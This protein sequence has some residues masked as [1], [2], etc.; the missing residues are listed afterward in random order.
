[1]HP[2]ADDIVSIP[3]PQGAPDVALRIHERSD[4]KADRNRPALF[5]VHGGGMVIG[6]AE[7]DD[8]TL[9]DYLSAG[10]IVAIAVDYRLAPENPYP[11]P[12]DDMWQGLV[13]VA[14]HATEL[15][16]DLDRL[17]IGGV[18]AGGGLAALLVLMARDRKGP[19]ISFQ[20][21]VEPMLDHRSVVP[22]TY[23]EVV[24]GT[25]TREMNIRGWKALLG[26]LDEADVTGHASPARADD[27][28]GLPPTYIEVGSAELFRDEAIEYASRLM[29]SGVPVEL[30]VWPGGYHSYE[31][32]APEARIS[33]ATKH[34][35]IESV[36]RAFH[37]AG[38]SGNS[39]ASDHAR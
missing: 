39:P 7:E 37:P 20:L 35:R 14:E 2:D 29:T 25:W 9:G 24:P 3:G 1:L 23:G 4:T 34:V 28:T 33:K 12:H 13:W 19:K 15:G 26:D 36:A 5:W 18:S 27:L 30:H 16:V 8:N 38:G 32:F 17:G 6:T 10:G 21:L 31:I 22:S 11:A